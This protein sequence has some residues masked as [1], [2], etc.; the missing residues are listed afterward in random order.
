MIPYVAV[1]FV[2]LVLGYK[3]GWS[4][5]DDEAVKCDLERERLKGVFERAKKEAYT[6]ARADLRREKIA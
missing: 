6:E 2:C 3:L 1:G 5:R 4:M